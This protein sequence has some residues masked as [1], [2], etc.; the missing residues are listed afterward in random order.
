[1][2]GSVVRVLVKYRPSGGRVAVKYR[3]ECRP[4]CLS[5]DVGR[6]VDRV[7]ADTSAEYQSIYWPSVGRHI[8]R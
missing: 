1:M 4:T 3:A 2:S 7:S 6:Y 5:V 8:G